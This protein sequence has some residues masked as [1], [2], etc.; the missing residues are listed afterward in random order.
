[1]APTG[2]TGG[3]ESNMSRRI[4][5]VH[6]HDEG[7]REMVAR[8]VE[9]LDLIPVILRDQANKGRAIITKFQE[10]ASDIG[11][12][13]VVMTPDDFGAKAGATESQPRARQNVVFELG[14]FIG[15]LGPD[16]VA[17]LIRGAVER[18]SDFDGVVYI[19]LDS[20]DWKTELGRELSAS[21][22]EIDW[23]LVMRG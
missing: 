13:V 15:K 4:F 8:F 9:K 5:I 7:S 3:H 18:P 17:A 6:G 11:F 22:Y 10:E 19:S 21:G 16:R 20:A 1:V 12:A 23:N 2:S 14:F